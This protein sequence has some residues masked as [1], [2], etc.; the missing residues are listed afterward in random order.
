MMGI[1]KK[2]GAAAPLFL[3]AHKLAVDCKEKTHCLLGE[4]FFSSY[5]KVPF[6]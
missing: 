5:F 6:P 4:N 1:N 3:Y 2:R